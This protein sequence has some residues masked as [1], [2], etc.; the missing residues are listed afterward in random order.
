MRKLRLCNLGSVL[1]GGGPTLP[2][3]GLRQ[4]A[5]RAVAIPVDWRVRPHC[6]TVPVLCDA[7][8]GGSCVAAASEIELS[9]AEALGSATT[10]GELAADCSV[11]SGADAITEGELAMRSSASGVAN[12]C[13]VV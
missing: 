11:D 1:T 10:G 13:C 6:A 9:D 12:S 2:I 3:T 5:K 4:T 8:A 7:A